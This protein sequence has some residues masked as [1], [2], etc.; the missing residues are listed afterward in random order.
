MR[1]G[2]PLLLAVGCTTL[3]ADIPAPLDYAKLPVERQIAIY[4]A[5]SEADRKIL[6]PAYSRAMMVRKW[7]GEEV[8]FDPRERV[9]V[10]R[11]GLAALEHLWGLQL[12][13][14]LHHAAEA[15]AEAR[16]VPPGP[17]RESRHRRSV[18]IYQRTEELG[19]WSATLFW[20]AIARLA[21]T[22]EA[23]TLNA[24]VA[25]WLQE[26]AGFPG[27]DGRGVF[28]AEKLPLCDR[29]VETVFARIQELPSL[30]QA[31]LDREIAA[32]PPDRPER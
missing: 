29:F 23:E 24:E 2:T 30:T 20:P 7:R 19:Q 27:P 4:E 9:A 18:E 5:A 26:V 15:N 32:L 13:W 3:R 6:Y 11:R 1:L 17:E 16:A 22:P 12:D 31:Q 25:Q 28:D 14:W 10:E 21:K 8:V